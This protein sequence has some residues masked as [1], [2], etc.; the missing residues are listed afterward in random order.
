[1]FFFVEKMDLL[2]KCKYLNKLLVFLL[3]SNFVYHNVIVLRQIIVKN[4]ETIIS[5]KWNISKI[6]N[7]LKNKE[8]FQEIFQK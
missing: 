7:C 1:M 6:M 5:L 3:I 4:N 2:I 8:I